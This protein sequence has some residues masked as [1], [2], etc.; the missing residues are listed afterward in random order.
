MYPTHLP[1]LTKTYTYLLILLTYPHIYLSPKY[2]SISTQLFYLSTQTNFKPFKLTS[3]FMQ[4]HTY[5]SIHLSTSP[6][7]KLP[8]CKTPFITIFLFTFPFTLPAI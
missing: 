3:C 2:Q 6:V 5:T 8:T 1:V 4:L 7:I